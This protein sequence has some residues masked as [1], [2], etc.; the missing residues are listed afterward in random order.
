MQTKSEMINRI[1]ELA[2]ENAELQNKLLV[3]ATKGRYIYSTTD[4]YTMGKIAEL[5]T[6]NE[7]LK[8]EIRLYDCIE[9]WGTE[10][11][12]CAY[13]CLGN[14]FCEDADK[15][16]DKYKKTLQEIKAIAE[17]MYE[18]Y[19]KRWDDNISEGLEQIIDLINKA[20]SEEE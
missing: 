9:K 12:R 16:I 19:S 14:E 15:R 6:E 4:Q 1:A 17:E 8:K 18:D 20:E 3:E 5:E 10:Q 11:C 2:K 13:R 7:R